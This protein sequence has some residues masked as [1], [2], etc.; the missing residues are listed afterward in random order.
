MDNNLPKVKV[1][2]E[3]AKPSALAQSCPVCNSFGT[4]SFGKK[5]CHG[6]NGKGY[7][8]IPV[9]GVKGDMR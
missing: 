2:V 1:I 8:L 7:I 5:V 4:L 9:E 3:K 6:C